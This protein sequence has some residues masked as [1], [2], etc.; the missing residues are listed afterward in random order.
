MLVK[1]ED[2]PE[3]NNMLRNNY[4]GHV[5]LAVVTGLDRKF[6]IKNILA[7][8][9]AAGNPDLYESTEAIAIL[10]SLFDELEKKPRMPDYLETI[11]RV[12]TDDINA[13]IKRAQP[14][15]GIAPVVNQGLTT[16]QVLLIAAGIGIVGGAC[17]YFMTREN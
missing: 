12:S 16:G 6:A 1:V 2:V 3:L 8:H 9:A 15:A 10:N 7:Q 11:N 5:E 13:A 14:I 17:V 4:Y